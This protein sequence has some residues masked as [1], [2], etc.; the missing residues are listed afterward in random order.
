MEKMEQGISGTNVATGAHLPA[1]LLLQP[2][3]EPITVALGCPDPTE[4]EDLSRMVEANNIRLVPCGSAGELV[5][6]L[7]TQKARAA[8]R[9]LLS[10]R[11]V[12]VELERV[13]GDQKGSS[14]VGQRSNGGQASLQLHRA[15]LMEVHHALRLVGPV[16]IDEGQ[17]VE[18]RAEL[19]GKGARLLASLGDGL[20]PADWLPSIGVLSLSRADDHDRNQAIATSLKAGESLTAELVE[21]GHHAV[22]YDIRIEKAAAHCDL[23]VTPDGTHGNLIFR[24][25]HY[26]GKL[27]AW[28]A[29]ALGLWPDVVF[30]DSSR[31]RESFENPVRTAARLAELT[32]DDQ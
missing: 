2:L 28:G 22:H 27:P 14:Y 6:T 17:T 12:T 18:Q 8:V 32:T 10:A 15:V 21:Q 23:L 16:G 11:E 20:M 5:E 7:R 26:L 1:N 25:L 13:F 31:A 30:V 4:L 9:G 3:K 29:P 19:A 24:T